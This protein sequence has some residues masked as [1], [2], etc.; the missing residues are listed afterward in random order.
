MRLRAVAVIAAILRLCLLPSAF[1]ASAH[2]QPEAPPPAQAPFP[3][4][5]IDPA[6]S[7]ADVISARDMAEA[8][9]AVD[10]KI[11][12]HGPFRFLVDTGAQ[13]TVVGEALATRLALPPGPDAVVTGIAGVLPVRTV[14]LE[15]ITLGRRQYYGLLAP[16]LQEA[17]IGADGIIGVDSLQGQR[18]LID[19]RRERL[20]I[21]EPRNAGTKEGYEIVV[22]ARRRSGQLVMTDA[23]IDGV[24]V[25]VI[26]DTGADGSI[27][28]LPLLA[29]LGKRGTTL[30]PIVITSVTGQSAPAH[31][32]VV[33]RLE[34]HGMAITNVAI[35]FADAPPFRS[36][37]LAEKPALLLGMH[38]LRVFPR[39]AID[40]PARRVLFDLPDDLVQ[41]AAPA[42]GLPPF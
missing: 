10:V 40:F 12:P 3:S 38:E 30:V 19:F 39:I 21:D 36:L 25:S 8:R 15:E 33:R 18:L 35:A 28:N 37:G 1:A 6:A 14:I 4:G 27:G 17:N 5:K 41:A 23:R 42:P 32:A 13:N 7:D 24:R 22:T 29:A 26:L 9:M 11:G 31:I 2:G 34:I 16:L 20:V